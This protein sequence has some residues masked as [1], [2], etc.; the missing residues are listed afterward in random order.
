M[1]HKKSMAKKMRVENLN[2]IIV[3]LLAIFVVLL[4]YFVV[5]AKYFGFVPLEI[6]SF[7]DQI[8]S[9]TDCSM[10]GSLEITNMHSSTEDAGLIAYW[11]FSSMEDGSFVDLVAGRALAGNAI[12]QHERVVFSGQDSLSVGCEGRCG[13]TPKVEGCGIWGSKDSCEAFGGHG[14]CAWSDICSGDLVCDNQKDSESCAGIQGCTWGGTNCYGTPA[15]NCGV[16]STDSVGCS[17]FNSHSG[18]CTWK[19]PCKGYISCNKFKNERECSVSSG[20]FWIGSTSA[21][22]YCEGGVSSCSQWDTDLAGCASSDYH[23]GQ[24]SW[25]GPC[26]GLLSCESQKD[27][28][29]CEAVPG[30][31]FESDFPASGAGNWSV[32]AW[33]RMKGTGVDRTLFGMGDAQSVGSGAYLRVSADGKAY[34][35]LGGQTVESN[36]KVANNL[37]HYVGAVYDGT[38]ARVYIDGKKEGESSINLALQCLGFSVGSGGGASNLEGYVDEIKIYDSPL[39]DSDVSKLYN[40]GLFRSQAEFVSRVYDLGVESAI[41]SANW[42]SSGINGKAVIQFRVSNDGSTWGDWSRAYSQPGSLNLNYGRY[43]QYRVGLQTLDL[44]ESPVFNSLSLDYQ[45]KSSTLVFAEPS[46][47]GRISKDSIVVNLATPNTE[48]GNFE[49]SLYDSN[50]LVKTIKSDAPVASFEGLPEGRY[51]VE[52]TSVGLGSVSRTVVISTKPEKVGKIK[53]PVAV[54][55]AETVITGAGENKQLTQTP[56]SADENPVRG[57]IRS[58]AESVG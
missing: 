30:C 54:E 15:Y 16:W 24:C 5:E 25:D 17:A 2:K 29:S 33:V 26:K 4:L 42:D 45:S 43:I 14:G 55:G 32:F 52:A 19:N 18:D 7:N 22:G 50:G 12:E 27:S 48:A 11:Q 58:V 40:V 44:T 20:C 51:T 6:S 3:V 13:G 1:A 53:V 23:A 8:G 21:N 34:L 56:I 36:T 31:K 39:S 41:T 38:T 49:I 10:D 35:D 28:K 46:D 47:V 9:C 57:F 37:W